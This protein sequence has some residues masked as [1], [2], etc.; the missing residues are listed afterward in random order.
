MVERDPYC[1]LLILL[2][3]VNCELLL[4]YSKWNK[5]RRNCIG[6][7]L[8]V[9]SIIK[10]CLCVFNFSGIFRPGMNAIMGPTGSGKTTYVIVICMI[11]MWRYRML[12][13]GN[14]PK[15]ENFRSNGPIA[16]S[17][18]RFNNSIVLS[19]GEDSIK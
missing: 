6:T 8:H 2:C 3:W 1:R 12:V 10:M 13:V 5:A 7:R 11:K 4:I 17:G 9:H 18:N 15:Q 14:L 19:P 16:V